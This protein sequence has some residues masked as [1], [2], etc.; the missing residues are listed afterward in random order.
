MPYSTHILWIELTWNVCKS[1][2]FLIQMQIFAHNVQMGF[3][4]QWHFTINFVT[5]IC[6]NNNYSRSISSLCT[7][8]KF[9]VMQFVMLRLSETR[10]MSQFIDKILVTFEILETLKWISPWIKVANA[11]GK[12]FRTD[13][14]Q[15]RSQM[16]S[17]RIVFLSFTIKWKLANISFLFISLGY[18]MINLFQKRYRFRFEGLLLSNSSYQKIQKP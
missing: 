12:F 17:K 1:Q 6:S 7:I 9:N 4:Y 18:L 2:T 3:G 15:N 13:L 14:R 11:N 10:D 16:K 8:I 5:H